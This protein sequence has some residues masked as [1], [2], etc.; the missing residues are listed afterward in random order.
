[1]ILARRFP[2]LL[3]AL[4]ALMVQIALGTTVPKPDPVAAVFSTETLCHPQPASDGS[5]HRAPPLDCLVCP[6]CLA[7]HAAAAVALPD[8]PAVRPPG[9]RLV[10]HAPAPFVQAT[11]PPVP[12]LPGQPRAPPSA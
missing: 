6:F 9:S 4:V 12:R 3:A 8:V 11:A 2:G 1:M 7:L 10:L 5:N